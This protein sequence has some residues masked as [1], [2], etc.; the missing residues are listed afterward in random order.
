M[1]VVDM[2]FLFYEDEVMNIGCWK[3]PIQFGMS[4]DGQTKQ[5]D[6]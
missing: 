6:I 3:V 5:S 4:S 2:R 1:G